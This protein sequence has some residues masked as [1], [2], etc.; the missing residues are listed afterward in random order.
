MTIVAGNAAIVAARHAKD[1]LRDAAA[2]V[3]KDEAS[4]SQ[5][6]HGCAVASTVPDKKLTYGELVRAHIWRHG[7]E[8]IHVQGTWDANTVMHDDQ[9]YGNVAPAY[10]FAAQVV[11]VEVDIDTGQVKVIDSFVNRV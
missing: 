9:L 4:E 11:E 3:L 2:H 8:G 7:G 10:S 1:A 5:L 6:I